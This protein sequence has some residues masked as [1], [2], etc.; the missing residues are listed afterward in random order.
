M[1]TQNTI[2][3][4]SESGILD[5]NGSSPPNI[6]FQNSPVIAG[7]V[8]GEKVAVIVDKHTVW[9]F[10]EG[11]WEH[12]VS[13]PVILNC[14]SWTLDG[15]LF[16]GTERARLAWV[17]DDELTFIEEFDAVPERIFWNT[18]WGGPPDTRSLAIAADGTVYADI[19]VGWIVRSRD[20][21]KTWENVREGLDKDVHQ[22]A[23]HPS[24]PATVFAATGNGFHISHNHG[25]AFARR[26][27]NLPY[28]YQ[29]ACMCFTEQD[30]YLVST[31]RGPRGQADA[32]L[33]RS[34][35][36]GKTWA[37]VRGLPDK[38]SKNINTYHIIPVD[39]AQALVIIDDTSLYETND[40]GLTW[41]KIG[42][43]YPRLYGALIV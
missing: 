10:I 1:N 24:D 31:S 40:W 33:Y 18:P 28:Q 29:R 30:V 41:R 42:S 17:Q 13:T 21:G 35:D 2:W 34:E 5:L 8:Q 26:S 7:D 4:L 38:I 32:L 6:P 14:I 11:Q 3:L 20:A 25:Q 43:E 22:V 37:V 16:V 23:A 9:T 27:E 12:V 36:A 19:H 39:R 15:R